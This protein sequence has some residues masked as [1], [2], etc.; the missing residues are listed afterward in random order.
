[1]YVESKKSFAP[2]TIVLENQ[3]EIDAVYSLF[4]HRALIE[5]LSP[6]LDGWQEKLQPFRSVNY[7][8]NHKKVDE[9]I[10]G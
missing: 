8:K 1:M 7:S 9:V 3:E 4:N 5:T 6:I 10:R 2:I